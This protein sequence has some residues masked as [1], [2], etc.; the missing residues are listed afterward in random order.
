MLAGARSLQIRP[1]NTQAAIDVATTYFQKNIAGK[2][3][4]TV[5]SI[6]FVVTDQNQALTATGDAKINSTFLKVLGTN[7]LTVQFAEPPAPY[8]SSAA[9]NCHIDCQVTPLFELSRA[10]L[11]LFA[12]TNLGV[13]R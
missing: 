3:D 5:N 9:E 13:K 10:W 1:G 12:P 8:F 4:L 7:Q 11:Y 2:V 6:A